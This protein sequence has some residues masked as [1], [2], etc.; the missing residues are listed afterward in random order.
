VAAAGVVGAIAAIDLIASSRSAIAQADRQ[1]S[2]DASSSQSHVV[3]VN[4]TPGECY[5]V[6]LDGRNLPRFV[7]ALYSVTPIDDERA[8]WLVYGPADWKLELT[9]ETT[10][11][12][13]GKRIAWRTAAGSELDHGGVVLFEVASGNRGTIVRLST[14]QRAG[15]STAAGLRGAAPPLTLAREDLRRFKQLIE[16]GVVATT[17]GQRSHFGRAA[18]EREPFDHSARA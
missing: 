2:M 17:C 9:V 5:E 7:A 3:T 11:D 4:R 6:W 15:A 12:D 1:R 14:Y 10:A 18:S 13:T 8:R 16:A